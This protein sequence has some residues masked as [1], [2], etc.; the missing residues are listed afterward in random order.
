MALAVATVV[1]RMGE[2]ALATVPP[3]TPAMPAGARAVLQLTPPA[4][5][6]FAVRLGQV[7]AALRNQLQQI[8]SRDIV[9]VALVGDDQ[10]A[11]YVMDLQGDRLRLSTADGLQLVQEFP[12]GAPGIGASLAQE[13]ARNSAANELL[14]LDH[15]NSALR[16]QAQVTTHPTLATRGLTVVA[17]SAA[18]TYHVRR[19][20]EPRSESNS[21]Q[22]E[23]SVDR[24]AYLTIFS[25][26]SQGN[27]TLLFPNTYSRAG[28]YPD[29]RV[30]GGEPVRIPDSLSP[31]NRAGF[32]WDY[33]PP[34]GIDTIRVF[35]STDAETA[36]LLRSRAQALQGLRTRALE[37]AGESSADGTS[38]DGLRDQ[39]SGL[40][41]RGIRLV[42][43]GGSGGTT[44]L[45]APDWAATSVTIA[46]SE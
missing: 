37:N 45:P 29:G 10:P 30:R 3:G 43:D 38:A 19:A 16:L 23:I 27:T 32:F 28:F 41:T 44:D 26:D 17:D 39:L 1:Q 40:A 18:A 35:A 24:D 4:A 2:D 5:A 7:P 46:L 33:S 13:F 34:A 12:V 15:P 31:G 6:S 8:F 36:R 11:R 42:Q 22:L 20:G 21:L 14:A 25:V 9:N